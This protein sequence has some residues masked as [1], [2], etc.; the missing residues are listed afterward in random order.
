MRSNLSSRV[1]RLPQSMRVLLPSGY[2]AIRWSTM[3]ITCR[4]AARP[5]TRRSN[6][7]ALNPYA[8]HQTQYAALTP[9]RIYH[10]ARRARPSA[11]S[12][13]LLSC[14]GMRRR[15]RF[16]NTLPAIHTRI[17]RWC[18]VRPGIAVPTLVSFPGGFPRAFTHSAWWANEPRLPH[19]SFIFFHSTPFFFLLIAATLTHPTGARF[20]GVL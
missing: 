2:I 20:Y 17:Y 1:S 9:R 12:W 3:S 6:A 13:P 16:C 5:K 4:A 14:C 19:L 7:A 18:L 10:S 15:S 8:V 11:G